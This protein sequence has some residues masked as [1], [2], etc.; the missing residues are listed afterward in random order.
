MERGREI[1]A[2]KLHQTKAKEGS[3]LATGTEREGGDACRG[4]NKD[5][6]NLYVSAK[7]PERSLRTGWSRLGTLG[8]AGHT[9]T[10]G[11]KGGKA[12]MYRLKR[13]CRN[14][15]EKRVWPQER[16]IYP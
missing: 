8:D 4:Q 12:G 7:G 5:G 9:K 16:K 11:K 15:A 14:S 3:L 10:W 1:Y 13:V 6:V 2:E